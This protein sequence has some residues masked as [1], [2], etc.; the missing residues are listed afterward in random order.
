MKHRSSAHT[1]VQRR[2]RE[3][4]RN[5]CQICGST[6]HAEGH[7]LVDYAFGGAANEDNIITLCHECHKNVHNG[8]IDLFKF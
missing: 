3:R 4:D 6:N 8:L 7:H 1:T 2:G 5:T